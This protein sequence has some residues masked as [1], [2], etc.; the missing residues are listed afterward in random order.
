MNFLYFGRYKKR[1][2]PVI[3]Q[4]KDLPVNSRILELCFGDTYIAEYCKLTGFKWTGIDLN[5]SFVA[6]ARKSGYEAHFGDLTMVESLP[7]SDVCIMMGSLYHFHLQAPSM[8]MKM[9]KTSNALIVSEPVLNLS[10]SK[11]LAGFLAKRAASVGKGNEVFRYN[12]SS[13]MAMLEENADPLNYHIASVKD[14]GKDLVIK[15]I[16]NGRN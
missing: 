8:L 5:E 9:L 11:G 13:L 4:I 6:H 3:D 14:H 7:M 1:F 12:R 2:A 16:K 10:S 15:L